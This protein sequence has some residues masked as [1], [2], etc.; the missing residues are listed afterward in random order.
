MTHWYVSNNI[1]YTETTSFSTFF[2][3]E[4]TMKHYEPYAGGRIDCYCDDPSHPDYDP[5]G[6]NLGIPIMHAKSWSEFSDFLR[7]F[8]SDELLD[9]DKLYTI[10]GKPLD[11]FKDQ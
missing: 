7:G 5:Y 2:N 11:I 10:Y 9:F 8:S 3:K 6:I 1:S 4:I